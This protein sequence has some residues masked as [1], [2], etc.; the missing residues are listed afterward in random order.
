MGAA[1]ERAERL[2]PNAR[3]DE[4]EMSMATKLVTPVFRVSFP[5]VFE[6]KAFDGGPPKYSVSAVWDPERFTAAEK[7]Q[8]QA[9]VDLCDEVSMERFKKK[10]S[11]LP[12]NF[13][14]AIRDGAEKAEL[15]GYGEG[16]LF[17]NLSSKMRPGVIGLDRAPILDADDFYPGCYARATVTAYSY[18]NK[19]KG[20]ALGLQNLM[21]VGEGDRLDSR[22]DASED[23]GDVE[24]DDRFER[25]PLDE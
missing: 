2:T 24:D 19:G 10:M 17:A 11:A 16:K 14:R 13:K 5:A 6:A 1:A 3:I 9:I 7:R 15:A 23:F 25:D 8:W 12:A 21:K 4:G 22:T 18:D 20:V